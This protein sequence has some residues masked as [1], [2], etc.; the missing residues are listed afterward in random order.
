[1]DL[2]LST[3]LLLQPLDFEPS[4]PELKVIGVFNPG[5]V[6][7]KDEV[8]ALVRVAEAPKITKEGYFCSPRIDLTEGKKQLNIDCFEANSSEDPRKSTIG[9]GVSRLSSISRLDIVRLDQTGTIVK[10]IQQN[11]SLQSQNQ[12]ETYGIEDPRITKIDNKYHITYVSV[13]AMCGVTTSLLQTSDFIHFERLGMIFDQDTKDVV[14]FPEKI[15]GSYGAYLRPDSHPSYHRLTIMYAASP[16]LIHWGDYKY[17]MDARLNSWDSFR[18]GAGCPPIKTE[19]GWLSIYHGVNKTDED[20][21]GRYSAGAVLTDLLNPT[22]IIARSAE[23][24]FSPENH[25]ETN[26]FSGR[27][28]FPT[29]I[30]PHHQDPDKVLV[31]YG[32]SDSN[33]AVCELSLNDIFKSLNN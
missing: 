12:Y 14:L 9:R 11:I 26:G 32:A 24:I 27:V 1:M 22:K 19:K 18:I 16:D 28:V 25:Y 30:V 17:L 23:P 6:R 21:V 5:V 4:H 31:Y 13:S 29:G 3:K 8:I 10:T 15:D 2:R 20:P 33:V 7:Y